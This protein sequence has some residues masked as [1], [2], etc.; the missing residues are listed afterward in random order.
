MIYEDDYLS[1]GSFGVDTTDPIIAA[2]AAAAAE[3]RLEMIERSAPIG[4]VLDVG[5]GSGEA[6]V[7]AQRRG[8]RVLGVELV[9]ASAA[10]ARARGV[11]VFT[12]TLDDLPTTESFDVV[13]AAHVLEHMFEP[14]RFLQQL[15]DRARPAGLV[16]VEVPNWNHRHRR[17][18]GAAWEQLRPLEHVSHFTPRTLRS[19]M[20]LA[21]LAPAVKTV[22]IVEH[23]PVHDRL[24]LGFAIVALARV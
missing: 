23:T 9:E 4:S 11:D 22:T 18:Q 8:W 10:R 19:T 16:A 7:V 3:R 20:R 2:I 1:G 21:G 13:M 5:C 17:A 12:G 14:V 15:A 24:G 6:L